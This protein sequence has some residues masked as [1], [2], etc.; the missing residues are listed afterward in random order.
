MEKRFGDHLL[1]SQKD[2]LELLLNRIMKSVAAEYL[3]K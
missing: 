2:R 1:V 3:I